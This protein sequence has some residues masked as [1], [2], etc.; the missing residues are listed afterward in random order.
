VH[1]A[2]GDAAALGRG[3]GLGRRQRGEG[4]VLGRRLAAGAR[5]GGRRRRRLLGGAR[6][7]ARAALR[8]ALLRLLGRV[9]RKRL[10]RRHPV[11]AAQH[12]RALNEIERRW[13]EKTEA[14]GSW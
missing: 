14:S 13:R 10:R 4:G 3:R 2:H 1:G 9:A 11:A 12:T 5:G 8:D 7:D 6:L